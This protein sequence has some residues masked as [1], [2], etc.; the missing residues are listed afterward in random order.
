MCITNVIAE[1]KASRLFM[2]GHIYVI[3]IQN[4]QINFYRYSN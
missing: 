3:D 4:E 1:K 2:I